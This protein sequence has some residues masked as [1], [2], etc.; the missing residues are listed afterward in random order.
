MTNLDD[1]WRATREGGGHGSEWRRSGERTGSVTGDNEGG[2]HSEW[3]SE[4]AA[5]SEDGKRLAIEG[6]IR[7]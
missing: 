2:G 4:K 6:I 5:A 7:E 1:A 3:R